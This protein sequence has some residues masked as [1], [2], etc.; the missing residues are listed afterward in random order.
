MAKTYN[1]SV[2]TG[3]FSVTASDTLSIGLVE[4]AIAAGVGL[5]VRSL[6]IPERKTTDG[7]LLRSTS[8]VWDEIVDELGANWER[9]YSLGARRW[10][11]L[12]AG[13]FTKDGY[14]VTLT[15]SSKDH[16]RDLIAVKRGVGTVKIIGSVKAYKRDL[17]VEYDAIRALAFVMLNESGSKGVVLTTSDFPP[18]V[19][20]DPYLKKYLRKTLE[21][22]NGN[23]LQA[24]LKK[25]RGNS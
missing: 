5:T 6:I 7:V 14:E 17:K 3:V 9:A 2:E 22:V 16:G 21:L 13:A 24:W 8:L 10:E 15:P 19:Y 20:E 4:E 18:L 12:I 23:Q 11:E 1:M 25:V